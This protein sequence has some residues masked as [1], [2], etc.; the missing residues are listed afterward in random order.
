MKLES[1]FS[2]KVGLHLSLDL[3]EVLI[4]GMCNEEQQIYS[5]STFGWWLFVFVCVCLLVPPVVEVLE[6]PFNSP[7]Q[8]RVANQRIAFPCP[9]KGVRTPLVTTASDPQRV[10][11]CPGSLRPSEAGDP[12]AA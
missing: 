6:P 12:V 7:L 4:Y 10:T 3:N 2:S 5:I 11:L 9:A 1:S 8:E